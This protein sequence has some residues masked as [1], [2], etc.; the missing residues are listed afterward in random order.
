MRANLIALALGF[1]PLK[2]PRKSVTDDDLVI[3]M[4]RLILR[5]LREEADRLLDRYCAGYR[6]ELA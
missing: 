5:G 6:V 2:C 4:E 3:A 1:R